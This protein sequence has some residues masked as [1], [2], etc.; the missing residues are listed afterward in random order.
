M[1]ALEVFVLVA[2]VMWLFTQMDV[3]TYQPKCLRCGGWGKHKPG[4]KANDE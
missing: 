3:F 4:C 1:G 2:A